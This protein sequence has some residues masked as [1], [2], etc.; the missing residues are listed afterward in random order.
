M[1]T[2][3]VSSNYMAELLQFS[4]LEFCQKR[5]CRRNSRYRVVSSV[6]KTHRILICWRLAR[7]HLEKR[8]ISADKFRAHSC[9]IS[10]RYVSIRQRT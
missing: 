8:L 10:F 6:S 9:V 3:I 1:R 5:M 7:T 4:F 2:E